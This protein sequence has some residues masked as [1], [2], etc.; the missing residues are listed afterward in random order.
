MVNIEEFKKLVNV[1]IVEKDSDFYCGNLDLAGRKYVTE[2]PDNLKVLGSLDLR[3]TSITKL[4]KGLEVER[5]ID[6]SETDIE[7]LPEDTML[8]G[9]LAVSCMKKPFSFP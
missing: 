3:Q 9:S 7:E 4:P 8:G 1:R 5:T 6:I 2:L